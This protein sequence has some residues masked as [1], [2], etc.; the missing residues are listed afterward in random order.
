MRSY[1]FYILS[2]HTKTTLYVGVTNNVEYRVSQH[3][4]KVNKGF[5]SKYNLKYLVYYEEYQYIDDAITRE[6]GVKKWNRKWKEKLI[7]EMNPD[8][9]DLS[10]EWSQE[11]T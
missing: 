9:K 8:W 4:A 7:K 2:N 11:I 10:D 1:Y 6:K 5:T 3:K